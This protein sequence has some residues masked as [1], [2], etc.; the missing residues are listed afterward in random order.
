MCRG[1]G[2]T[3]MVEEDT[4]P[5]MGRV[6]GSARPC[7]QIPGVLDKPLKS[8]MCR[9]C[10]LT[11]SPEP[12]QSVE[13]KTFPPV[14]AANTP[15]LP[16]AHSVTFHWFCWKISRRRSGAWPRRPLGVLGSKWNEGHSRKSWALTRTGPDC[17]F[18]PL[19]WMEGGG[20]GTVPTTARTQLSV[21]LTRRGRPRRQPGAVG[22]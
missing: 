5:E 22:S 19:N 6:M 18:S 9:R 14:C 17:L 20:R 1:N 7:P 13:T 10:V 15:G 2:K 3:K 8:G 16:I 11:G 12:P 4:L 21:I